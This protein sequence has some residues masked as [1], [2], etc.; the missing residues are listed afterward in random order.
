MIHAVVTMFVLSISLCQSLI[1]N[2]EVILKPFVDGNAVKVISGLNNY[3]AELVKNVA[4]AAGLG[5][6]SHIDIA[7]DPELVKIAKS[8]TTLPVCV[9]SIEPIK[10]VGAVA[11]G[12]DMIEIGNYDFL[13]SEGIFFTAEDI[14]SMTKRTRELLP[15]TVLS[16][17]IPHHLSLTEQVKLAQDLEQYQVDII[18]TE[19]KMSA[20]PTGQ[21]NVQ[22]LMALAIPSIAAS[23]AIS[24]AV[25]IPVMCASGLT[26]VTAPMALAAGARGVGIGSMV[27]KLPGLTQMTLAVTAV[28]Q[29]VGRKTVAAV[30]DDVLSVKS[31]QEM[32]VQPTVIVTK[33]QMM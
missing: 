24:R 22:E 2:R 25:K 5:G 11:A 12:A 17:T 30:S 14:I 32:V 1:L 28:A 13:Y 29:A 7:C 9:S 21:M 31:P 23:Y 6:A 16:V 3:N 4:T 26:D 27:N 15:S 8:V 10:F 33:A 18:Q 20:V 19:G